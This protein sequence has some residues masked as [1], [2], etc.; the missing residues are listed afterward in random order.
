MDFRRVLI[1]GIPNSGKTSLFNSLTGT[2]QKVGNWPGVTVE[3]I[4]GVFSFCDERVP[5]LDLPGV[6]NFSAETEDQ[7]IASRAIS[8]NIDELIINLMDASNLSR[9]LYL[10]FELLAR[11]SRVV[12]FLNMGE[13]AKKEG[14]EVD[15][16][17]LSKELGV[18]VIPVCAIDKESVQQAV[19][20]L[21]EHYSRGEIKKNP[22][23]K[24]LAEFTPQEIY[25]RIDGVCGKVIVYTDRD[26]ESLTDRIDRI[27]MNKYLVT[28]IFLFTM[29]LTFWVAIS[30]GAVFIDFFDIVGGLFFVDLPKQLLT[31]LSAPSWL[32][33]FLTDGIGT[34]IQTVATFIPV[35]YFMFTA[36][37]VLEDFGYMARIAVM[38]DRLMR[39]IGLPGSAFVPL[40]VGFGCTVPAVMAA[41]TLRSRTNRYMTIFM[42]PFMSCGARLP[43]YALFGAALFGVHSGLAVFLIYLTGVSVAIFTGFLLR[44]TLFKGATS[45][46]V[47]DLPLYHCP[48]LRNVLFSAW[49]R[50]NLFLRR[51]GLVMIVAVTVLSFFNSASLESGGL[52]L[53]IEDPQDSLL[54]YAGRGVAPLLTPL[55]VEETNWPAVVALFAGLFAKEAIIGSLNSLYASMAG[56]LDEEE[57]EVIAVLPTLKEAVQSIGGNFM[58]TLGTLDLLG[59]GLTTK[60]QEEIGEEVE[61]DEVVFNRIAQNFTPFSGFAYL[62]FVLMY[63][64][65]LAVV[66]AARQEM[67][68]GFALVLVMYATLVAWALATLFYQLVEGRNPLFIGVSL[69]VFALLYLLL[70]LLGHKME[71]EEATSLADPGIS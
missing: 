32:I 29:F 55:G 66:G 26:S 1:A 27:V 10:T 58:D 33:I 53:G 16:Q 70:R 48:K 54:A 9:S 18:P 50:L 40:V 4:E 71:R 59:V 22:F 47:M 21:E 6:N 52:T 61:A 42:A 69:S 14:R 44:N 15:A 64:P 56:S 12:V 34:G 49:I 7:K 41:R 57:E 24:D 62:L 43:V 35:V 13:I 28:P 60:S 65:C 2:H 68:G 67:G 51:A 3:R 23:H 5:L 8:E 17:A 31:N 63:F 36:I 37:A 39:R 11:G 38:A 19:A 46:F 20:S 25:D 45:T 30:L